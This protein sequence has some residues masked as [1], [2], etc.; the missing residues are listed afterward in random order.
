MA[1]TDGEMTDVV[2]TAD[3]LVV[4]EAGTVGETEEAI[5][6]DNK[7]PPLGGFLV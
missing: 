2:E 4:A 6:D 1:E 5:D 7:K 3:G